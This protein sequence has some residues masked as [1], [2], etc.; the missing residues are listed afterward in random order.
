MVSATSLPLNARP[1]HR[2]DKAIPLFFLLFIFPSTIHSQTTED[3]PQSDSLAALSAASILERALERS[4]EQEESEIELNFEY[5]IL[6]T[7]HTLDGDGEI[8]ET[9]TSRSR[10]FPLE[11]YLFEEI[12]ERDGETLDEDGI[13]KEREKK[14]DFLSKVRSHSE[15][16]E[17][18]E[19]DSMDDLGIIFNKELMRRYDVKFVR[20]ETL[21]GYKCW[22]LSFQP[23]PGK[24]PDNNRMDKALNQSAGY[25]WVAQKDFGVVR[26][27]FEMRRPFRYVWGIV[28]TIR[29]TTGQLD[30]ERVDNNMWIPKEIDLKLDLRIFFKN[31][32]RHISQEWLGHQPFQERSL[33]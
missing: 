24:L 7:I 10:R 26:V 28:A 30:F 23:R 13:K 17:A 11:G 16:G 4:L 5:S 3:S 21:R 29:N 18:Y 8:T 14:E 1:A 9:N 31:I 32:R 20:T 22:L 6:S 27:Y 15:K 12:L 2:L 19:P 33:D 25:L